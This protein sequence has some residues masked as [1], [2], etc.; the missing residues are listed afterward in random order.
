MTVIGVHSSLCY[1]HIGYDMASKIAKK[2]HHEGLTLKESALKLEAL[3][4]EQFD[5]WAEPLVVML[6]VLK[7]S[8]PHS[9]T[10]KPFT[11]S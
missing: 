7:M 1:R 9:T 5:E 3:T 10:L 11:W 6:R 8:V 4:S 2:A